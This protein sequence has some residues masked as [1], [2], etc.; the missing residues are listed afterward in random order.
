[1]ATPRDTGETKWL[2][3]QHIASQLAPCASSHQYFLAV[4]GRRQDSYPQTTVGEK[5]LMPCCL[6]NSSAVARSHASA[7]SPESRRRVS[8]RTT[9]SKARKRQW[10]SIRSRPVTESPPHEAWVFYWSPTD[11]TRRS[12]GPSASRILWAH[13]GSPPALPTR[14]RRPSRSTGSTASQKA[15]DRSGATI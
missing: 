6:V 8:T 2:L 10:R 9:S 11:R 4:T 15:P 1:M 7:Q 3:I 12:A 14:L 13:Q 5:R